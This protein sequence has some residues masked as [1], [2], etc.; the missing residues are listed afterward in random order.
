M[1]AAIL[2][3]AW[4]LRLK[5]NNFLSSSTFLPLV[6]VGA[7]FDDVVAVQRQNFISSRYMNVA[8]FTGPH[9]RQATDASAATGDGEHTIALTRT[10]TALAFSVDGRAVVEASPNDFAISPTSACFGGYP[11]DTVNDVLHILSAKWW[12]PLD[13]SVLPALSA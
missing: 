13:N 10:D 12:A 6:L 8:D 11:G 1:L 7:D 2:P 3:A 9:F 5:W 4:T